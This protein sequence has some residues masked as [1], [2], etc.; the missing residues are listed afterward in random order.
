MRTFGITPPI[1]H[2][3]SLADY[4]EYMRKYTPDA[5]VIRDVYARLES[6][7]QI[8]RNCKIVV[9]GIYPESMIDPNSK[10]NPWFQTLRKAVIYNS[11]KSR[12]EGI[13]EFHLTHFTFTPPD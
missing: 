3:A 9:Q 1:G 2:Y 7:N 8:S 13:V 11:E 4:L 5:N 10:E 12:E 6:I